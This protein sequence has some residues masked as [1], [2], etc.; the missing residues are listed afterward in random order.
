MVSRVVLYE[1]SDGENRILKFCQKSVKIR[2]LIFGIFRS[3]P[4][5]WACD[6]SDT[7]MNNLRDILYS[8]LPGKSVAKKI[9]PIS[10][11]QRP[12]E[13]SD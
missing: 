5:D 11:L 13:V 8:F 6:L 9:S 1:K 2:Q 3:F 4:Y 12:L 7:D 10:R